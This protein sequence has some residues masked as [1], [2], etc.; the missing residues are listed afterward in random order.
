MQYNTSGIEIRARMLDVVIVGAG[1]AGLSCGIEAKKH[2]LSHLLID[3]GGFADAIR[4]YPTTMNFNSTAEQL[5]LSDLPF[6]SQGMRPTRVEALRYYRS[7]AEYFKLNSKLQTEITG[8]NSIDG[9]FVLQCSDG[10]E[11]EAKTVVLATGYFERPVQLGVSGEELPHV[12]H[13]YDEPFEYA[14]SNVLI[15]GGANSAAD[16]ALDLYRNGVNVSIAH[17][18]PNF[19]DSLKY[20]VRPDIENRIKEGSI[21]AHFNTEVQE[22][23]KDSVLLKSKNPQSEKT[24]DAN[25]VFPLIGYRPDPRLFEAFEIDFDRNTLIPKYD[26]AFE[27]SVNGLFVAGSTVC[28]CETGNVFIE[29]GRLHAVPIIERVIERL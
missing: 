5:T 20:W 15:I 13:F 28:G 12:K 18:G 25:F 7:V 19:S 17:R 27:T 4:R 24:I 10:E 29:N 9:H 26:E 21:S 8:G 3:K 16:T 6:N 14:E 22:I 23:R 2:D 1:P 11:I